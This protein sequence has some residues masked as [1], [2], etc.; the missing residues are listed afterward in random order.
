MLIHD[1]PDFTPINDKIG[2][3]DVTEFEIAKYDF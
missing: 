1:D 3:Y 2:T